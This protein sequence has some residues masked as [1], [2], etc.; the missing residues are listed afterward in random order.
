MQLTLFSIIF[1]PFILNEDVQDLGTLSLYPVRFRF[2]FIFRGPKLCM[3]YSNMKMEPSDNHCQLYFRSVN[4]K[5]SLYEFYVNYIEK[6]LGINIC[7][8]S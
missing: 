2:S 3:I 5:N 7:T 4:L 6:I 8:S 1:F